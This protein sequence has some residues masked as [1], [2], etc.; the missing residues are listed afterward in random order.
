MLRKGHQV[1]EN[2]NGNGTTAAPDRVRFGPG[3]TQDMPREWAE[4]IL[5]QWRESNPAAFGKAL[6]R[7]ALKAP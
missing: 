4:M 3:K 1:D 6:A 2:S 7:V 5:T